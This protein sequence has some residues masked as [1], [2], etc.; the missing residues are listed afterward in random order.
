MH[1]C[2][3][4]E[5]MITLIGLFGLFIFFLFVVLTYTVSVCGS[6]LKEKEDEEQLRWIKEYV[7]KHKL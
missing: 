7:K 1:V 6:I 2:K 3:G 5:F 4:V